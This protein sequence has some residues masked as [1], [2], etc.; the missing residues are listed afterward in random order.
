MNKLMRQAEERI[1]DEESNK[2]R[3]REVKGNQESRKRK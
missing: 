1:C 2:G 3:D